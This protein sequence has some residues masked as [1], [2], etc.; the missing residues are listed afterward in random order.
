[1][2]SAE[3]R[4]LYIQLSND[5]EIQGDTVRS[6]LITPQAL[7]RDISLVHNKSFCLLSWVYQ[8]NRTKPSRNKTF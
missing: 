1:V 7:T 3:Q 8:F 4:K 5:A 6:R 2:Q